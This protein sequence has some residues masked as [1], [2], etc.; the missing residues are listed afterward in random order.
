M[1]Q[2]NT[3]CLNLDQWMSF[4][5]FSQTIGGPE[6]NFAGYDVNDPWPILLDEYVT[7]ATANPEPTTTTN[8]NPVPNFQD[9]QD[10]INVV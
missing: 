10:A 5:E 2:S 7:W 4:L 1:Q 6:T 3:K 9:F 8:S